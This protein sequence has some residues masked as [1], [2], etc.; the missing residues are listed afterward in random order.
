[1]VMAG[2]V[3]DTEGITLANI[4][5]GL[6]KYDRGDY[7]SARISLEKARAVAGKIGH[8]FYLGLACMYLGR[9]ESAFEEYQ[10]AIEKLNESMQIFEE[11]DAQDNLI[12][13]MC[14]LAECYLDWGDIEN[15]IHW[16]EM[17]RDA[18]T[19]GGSE[20]MGDSVQAGRVLRLQGAINRKRGKLDLAD[21]NL[22]ESANIFSAT[23]EKLESARTAYELGL[24]ALE[25]NKPEAA[26]EYFGQAKE[27]FSEVGAD[28]EL[29]RVETDLEILK[30]HG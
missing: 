5:L 30:V 29:L 25:V 20:P 10:R 16:S 1:M 15:A 26:D 6:V 28:K 8:R 27:I 21:Q 9:L 11:L 24:L 18:L 3:G 4:N 22:Q 2:W 7:E 13:A 12:D 19:S 23:L 17:S 14:Y